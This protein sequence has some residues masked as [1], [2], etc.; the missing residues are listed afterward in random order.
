MASEFWTRSDIDHPSK[1]H[2]YYTLLIVTDSVDPPK[3]VERP[4]RLRDG[5]GSNT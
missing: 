2:I 1:N 5:R 3:G 4:P